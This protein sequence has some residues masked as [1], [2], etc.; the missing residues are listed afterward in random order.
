MKMESSGSPVWLNIHY[1]KACHEDQ[2]IRVEILIN[3]Y[4]YYDVEAA[5]EEQLVGEIYKMQVAI[6][7]M[8]IKRFKPGPNLFTVVLRKVRLDSKR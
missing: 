5:K 8:H 6:K 3:N 7:F 2:K 1:S 4:F